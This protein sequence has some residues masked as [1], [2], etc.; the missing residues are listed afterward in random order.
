MR[1]TGLVMTEWR[2]LETM[3]DVERP[4]VIVW[5]AN[6]ADAFKPSEGCQGTYKRRPP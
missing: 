6:A 3:S 4:I 2:M 5:M 1:H